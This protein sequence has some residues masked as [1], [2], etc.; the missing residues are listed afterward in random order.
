MRPPDDPEV[1][2]WLAKAD[3]DVAAVAVLRAHAPALDPVIGFHCQ[4][5][6][7]KLLKALLVAWDRE[8][9]RTHDLGALAGALLRLGVDLG[10]IL[11]D[12]AFLSPFA[13]IPRYPGFQDT[14]EPP[15]VVGRDAEQALHRLEARVRQAFHPGNPRDT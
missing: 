15:G 8:P 3:E 14:G 11:E 1:A 13:V 9:E 10:P 7:E 4:Q 12:A 6:A 2:A 5:A